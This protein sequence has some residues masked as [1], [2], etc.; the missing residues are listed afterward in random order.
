VISGT[1]SSVAVNATFTANYRSSFEG[2]PTLASV[3]GT[4][5]GQFA[6]LGP[7]DGFLLNLTVNAA[8]DLSGT[9]ASGCNHT[10]RLTPDSKVNVYAVTVT[11]AGGCRKQGTLAGHALWQAAVGASPPTLTIFAISGDFRDGWLF[12]GGKS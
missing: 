1:L 5:A 10:G 8:G 11:F 7:G 6:G 4:Y 12:L 2:P 3:V 9:T